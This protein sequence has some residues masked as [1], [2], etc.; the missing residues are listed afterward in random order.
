MK[1]SASFNPDKPKRKTY[2]SL[3]VVALFLGWLAYSV[4]I[5]HMPVNNTVWALTPPV[6]AI[7]LALITKEVYS[8]LF[9]GMLTGALLN[10][11]FDPVEGL[12]RL[13]PNGIMAVLSDKWNVGILVF[14]VILGT[15]VQLMNRTG[16]SSAFGAWASTHIK[17]RVGA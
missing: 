10:T 1:L 3:L 14:L 11:R 5:N 7:S 2:L 15:M 8:S 17:T 12:N 13:F 6:M 16:G 4:G 9:M